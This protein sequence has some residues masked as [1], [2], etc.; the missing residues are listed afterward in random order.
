MGACRYGTSLQASHQLDISKVSAVNEWDIKLNTK[1][2][3]HHIYKQP[4]SWLYYLAYYLDILSLITLD[5]LYDFPKISNHFPNSSKDSS[6]I[7]WGPLRIG[8][9]YMQPK[10]EDFQGISDYFLIIHHQIYLVVSL[11]VKCDISEVINIFTSKRLWKIY[12]SSLGDGFVWVLIR[13][14]NFPVKYLCLTNILNT[15]LT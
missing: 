14:E 7:V 13:V 3:S 1:R 9:L 15:L 8:T 12:H 2:S 5:I 10:I 11:R 4:Y 6:K